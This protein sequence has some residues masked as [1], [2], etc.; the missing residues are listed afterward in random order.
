MLEEGG[1]TPRLDLGWEGA[2]APVTAPGGRRLG[3]GFSTISL[4]LAGGAVLLLGLSALD[5]ANFVAD[6]FARNAALGWVT[7]AVAGLGYGLILWGLGREARGLLSL[8]AVDRSRAAYASGDLA[9]ARAEALRWAERTPAAEAALPAL[10][11]APDLATLRALLDTGPLA[12]L[13]RDTESL[14]R[15]A[16]VQA[17]AAAAVSPSPAWDALL[18][19]W[20]GLRLVR[21]VAQLHGLRPG[22]AGTFALLRRVLLDAATVAAADVALDAAA[23]A[24]LTNPLLE[25]LAGEAATGAVAARRMLLLARATAA[26]CRITPPP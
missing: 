12:T 3:G 20:R 19:G 26:A 14:G 21:Q 6:Q 15:T 24:L 7:L 4:A 17:F 9:R 16:A 5:A 2:V 25:R 8:S 10:R 22:L 18:I 1:E 13:A 11:D 23:R